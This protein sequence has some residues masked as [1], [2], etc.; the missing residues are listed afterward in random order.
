[1]TKYLLIQRGY[2]WK[3]NARG[4]TGFKKEAG[5]YTKKEAEEYISNVGPPVTMIA[6]LAAPTKSEAQI[7]KD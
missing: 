3:T 7:K 1:M 6:E 5:R 2:Y 4:Y